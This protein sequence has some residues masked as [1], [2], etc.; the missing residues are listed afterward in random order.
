MFEEMERA[1]NEILLNS[2]EMEWEETDSYPQETLRKILR[3]EGGARSFLLKLPA[4]FHMDAHTHAYSEQHFV[5]GGEY[6]AEGKK[7]GP[8]SYHYIPARTDHGPYTSENG[9]V[10]LV[11]WEG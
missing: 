11:I 5:L 10:I 7:W 6:E 9:A 4:N 2:E 8:G 3:K 1:M